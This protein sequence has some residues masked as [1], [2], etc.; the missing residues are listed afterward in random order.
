MFKDALA[1]ILKHEGGYVNDPRDKGGET[2]F[3]I[4]KRSYPNT[5]IKNLTIEGASALYKRDFWDALGCD[6]LEPSLAL[7]AFDAGVNHGVGRARG[8]LKEAAGSWQA[9]MFVRHT[10][11]TELEQFNVYGRGW[12]RRW[13][14]TWNAAQALEGGAGGSLE[15]KTLYLD[16]AT[17]PIPVEKASVVGSKLYIH[18]RG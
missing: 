10:F 3:G 9:F 8:W 6:S 7:C 13:R 5:D 15:V 4:S 14:E 18:T 12:M 11:Y 16:S 1:L 2:K 17:D